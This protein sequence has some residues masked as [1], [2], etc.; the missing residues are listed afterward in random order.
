MASRIIP[1]H[2]PNTGKPASMRP[3]S[4]SNSPDESSSFDIVVDSAPR[5]HE[6]VD[7]VEIGRGADL[8]ASTPSDSS[9]C[10]WAAKAPC[11]ASTP[12]RHL[13]ASRLVAPAQGDHRLT[14]PGRRALV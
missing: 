11:R 12:T 13:G 4:G 9:A 5:H 7:P 2:V 6:G 3:A 10:A 14:S 8:R 1:A